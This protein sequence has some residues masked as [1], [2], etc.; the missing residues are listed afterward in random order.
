MRVLMKTQGIRILDK[1]NGTVSVNLPD[2]LEE[3][4]NGE[5]VHWSI[6][7]LY[8]VGDLGENESIPVFEQKINKSL[9]GFPIS[10]EKLNLIA[11]KIY[12]IYDI[13]LIA[14][15]NKELLHRY[16][17]DQ[18]MYETCDIV[19]EM[20]DC[21]FWEVFSKDEQLIQRLEKKFQHTKLLKADFEK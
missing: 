20:V 9:K 18:V 3:I 4:H 13:I 12:Q 7:Y 11:K 17:D 10:W 8:A 15:S 21:S 14:S 16:E 19:I 1:T 2:I 6:L 5:S